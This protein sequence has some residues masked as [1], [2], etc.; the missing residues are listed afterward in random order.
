MVWNCQWQHRLQIMPGI[1][2]LCTID[3]SLLAISYAQPFDCNLF[4]I[5]FW[6]YP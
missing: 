5:L 3:D 4:Q 1:N 2:V 6:K